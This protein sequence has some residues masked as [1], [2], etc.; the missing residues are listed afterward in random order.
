MAREKAGWSKILTRKERSAEVS[1]KSF[2][3][4]PARFDTLRGSVRITRFPALHS[5]I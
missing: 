5:L 3:A 2:T 1:S 4:G